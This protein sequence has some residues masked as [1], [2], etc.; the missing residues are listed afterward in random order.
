MSDDESN[1]SRRGLLFTEIA[2]I[3]PRSASFNVEREWGEMKVA[4]HL[5]W[6]LFYD[7]KKWK[8]HPVKQ[9]T[10]F[11]LKF[12]QFEWKILYHLHDLSNS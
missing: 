6:Q 3:P 10:Q 11:P 1:L 2:Q 9:N 12:S 7:R 4:K 8:W 5:I